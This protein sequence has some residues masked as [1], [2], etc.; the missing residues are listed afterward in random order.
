MNEISIKHSI[1]IVSF[2]QENYIL[3]AI[4]SIY[5]QEIPPYELIILDDR[6]NDSTVKFAKEYIANNPP[7][8]SYK[9]IVNEKNL[10]I[11][12]N[13]KKAAEVSTGNVLSILAAD[14]IWFSNGTRCVKSGIEKNQ[15]NPDKDN[16]VCFSPTLTMNQDG[17]RKFVVNYKIYK[18]S[19]LQTMVRKCAPFG[20]IGFSRSVLIGV[21]YPDDIGL[22]AD[23]V[24]DISICE[25]AEK[26][27]QINENCFVHY[28]NIGIS[29]KTDSR[30]IDRSYFMACKYLLDNY[31]K[32]LNFFDRLYLIG[33][34]SYLEWKTHGGFFL[35]LKSILL[36]LINLINS[37]GGAS[38]N[39][40][41]S[42]YLPS[43]IINI[44]R[45]LKNKN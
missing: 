15:L 12:R 1:V 4:K 22:W 31:K 20:K 44:M 24:W 35:Y 43:K 13:M 37:G 33:E 38:F 17:S 5:E 21:D 42:R 29:S 34:K 2:N 45:I 3:N 32:K 27:Y 39:S 16:F 25:K 26:Y 30:E 41:L 18:K 11:P 36:M 7:R 6:S 8:F 10:G 19:P 40:L 23:W 28:E 9:I 14:D